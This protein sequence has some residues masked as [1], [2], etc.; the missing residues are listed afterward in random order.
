MDEIIKRAVKVLKNNY[1]FRK[2]NGQTKNQDYR[3]YVIGVYNR[4]DELGLI[5]A[6]LKDIS[7]NQAIKELMLDDYLKEI[8]EYLG[9][10]TKGWKENKK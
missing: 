6:E 5:Y 1:C 10:T 2:N 7:F 9:L 3:E 4:F 8:K